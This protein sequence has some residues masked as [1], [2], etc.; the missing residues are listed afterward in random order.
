M[1]NADTTST[2][3]HTQTMHDTYRHAHTSEPDKNSIT[4]SANTPTHA[5][6]LYVNCN[7]NIHTQTHSAMNNT[8][9]EM[10]LYERPDY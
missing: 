10:E 2:V 1:V 5:H 9:I 3:A 4:D 8:E 7:K 6:T